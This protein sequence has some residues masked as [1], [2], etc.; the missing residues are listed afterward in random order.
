MAVRPK[1]LIA[2]PGE[3][4][5]ALAALLALALQRVRITDS[6]QYCFMPSGNWVTDAA[7]APYKPKDAIG[8]HILAG[9]SCWIEIGGVRT[10]LE[11]GDITAFP[12]GTPHQLGAG[13][14]GPE[15][16]PGGALTPPPWPET[17]ILRFGAGER[18]V[19]MLCGYVRCEAMHFAPFRQSLPEFIH[20]ATARNDD[21][22]AGIVA[23]IVREVD[24]PRG[25]G[26]AMLERLSEI[27]LLEVL[28]RQLLCGDA[29]FRGWLAAIRDPVVGR[30]LRLFHDDPRRPWTI[31]ELARAAGASRSVIAERFA[32]V[33]G[34]APIAYLRDWRLFLARER[35]VESN[36]AIA[37]LALEAGY[38]SEAAFS[39]AFARANGLPPAAYRGQNGRVAS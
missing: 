16:D 6:M 31:A 28:R 15:I 11:E 21:W 17:P 9:G 39:R 19:R 26:P 13:T 23:Q 14:D 3:G 8:F 20:V 24:A 4:E 2:K 1:A 34:T 37:V 10:V 12:F 29:G 27:A 36:A 30:C 18:V 5:A 7:P 22:L 33:L 32:A 38:A 25:G 35:L